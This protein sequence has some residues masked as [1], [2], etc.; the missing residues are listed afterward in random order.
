M[1]RVSCVLI[2]RATPRRYEWW[3]AHKKTRD[4]Q[5]VRVTEVSR[6]VNAKGDWPWSK[7]VEQGQWPGGGVQEA[8][9]PKLAGELA[10]AAW[11]GDLARVRSLLDS[12]APP[13]TEAHGGFYNGH[14]SALNGAARNGHA[15]IV[16]LLLEQPTKPDVESRCQSPWEVTPLQQAG[17]WGRAKVAPVLLQHGASLT[18]I[19][20]PGCGHKTAKQIAQEQ[21]NHQWE[22][23]VQILDTYAEGGGLSGTWFSVEKATGH[24]NGDR[25]EF[26]REGE[27]YYIIRPPG[28]AKKDWD[29]FTFDGTTTVRHVLGPTSTLLS[30][31]DL[32]WDLDGGKWLSRREEG[33]GAHSGANGDGSGGSSGRSALV[34]WDSPLKLRAV[35]SSPMDGNGPLHNITERG[36]G[37][38]NFGGRSG[39]HG[40]FPHWVIFEGCEGLPVAG[41]EMKAYVAGESPKTMVVETSDGMN[42]DSGPWRPVASLS[43]DAAWGESVAWARVSEPDPAV[44]QWSWAPMKLGRYLRLTFTSSFNGDAPTMYYTFFYPPSGGSS[45]GFSARQLAEAWCLS[46]IS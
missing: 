44:K 18:S 22:D 4:F 24:P 39:G 17:F 8:F 13:N 29:H 33:G 40:C 16:S 27:R 1:L 28:G 43:A 19:S 7:L 46:S 2:V 23:F 34:D 32:H 5:Y 41:V 14:H 15:A 38:A 31:G 30:S 25:Y 9:N 12:G 37:F 21:R 6:T 35:K 11:D 26:R 45:G 20:G 36:G 3:G 10:Q 42:P